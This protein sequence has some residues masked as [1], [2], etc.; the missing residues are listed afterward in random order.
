MK[1]SNVLL[2]LWVLL[3]AGLA[4]VAVYFWRMPANS[5]DPAKGNVQIVAPGKTDPQAK[6]PKPDVK[7]PQ[8][9][10]RPK[11][12]PPRT[13]P[14]VAGT[15]L[16]TEGKPVTGAVVRLLPPAKSAP[17]AAAANQE[18]AL[19]IAQIIAIADEDFDAI[20]SLAAWV[21]AP[22]AEGARV[23][24][25]EYGAMTTAADGRFSFTLMLGAG[26]GPYLLTARHEE[27]GS[28]SDPE[29]FAGQ[30]RTLTLSSGGV[31]T[32]LVTGEADGAGVPAARVVFDSGEREY[33]AVTDETG[34]F[35]IE[36]MPPGP[37]SVRAGAPGRT[38]ILDQN[39]KVVRGEPVKLVLPRGATIRLKAIVE[40]GETRRGE[41]PVLGGVEVVAYEELARVYLL[42][43][44]NDYGLVE[45]TGVP[46]GQWLVNGR[47]EKYVSQGEA[48]VK[49]DGNT[50][51]V[52]DELLFETAVMTP[53]QVVDDSGVGIPGVEFYTCDG[54]DAYDVLRSARLP[55]STD[56]DGKWSFPFEFD[57]PRCMIYGFKKGYGL[58]QAYPDDYSAGDPVRLV[59]KKA[60]R[61]RGK[62]VDEAGTV[63]PDAVVRLTFEP[64][65]D[66][67]SVQDSSTI[68]LRTDKAG[69]YDFPYLPFGYEVSV[70][71][72]SGEMW[73]DDLVTLDPADGKTD[74]EVDLRLEAAPAV[75]M[76]QGSGTTPP[77][78]P[79][80]G[81]GRPV[82]RDPKLD[83]KDD[84]K[85]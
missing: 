21:Q 55:G 53:V 1:T 4:L 31:V 83:T 60:M 52:E 27:L 26:K 37:F 33:A 34:A 67:A 17:P 74:H 75:R 40:D 2:A 24:G 29:W 57:G 70:E 56:A 71:A 35:R 61:V 7:A 46:A 32:G 49:V 42:G 76:V 11:N 77:P 79:N 48:I 14:I 13:P 12:E 36:G 3:V 73:S 65:D 38:P 78:A 28:A 20:R 43:R 81:D 41:E 44:T 15:I 62:V 22:A 19:R 64:M 66:D 50:P 82:P 16:D 84:G 47:V 54:F 30:D 25:P 39:V 69:R 10:V 9:R 85:K 58:V 63:V 80:V 8:P 45:F 51:V 23:A 18:E 59:M 5:S 72:E 68:Q 6:P